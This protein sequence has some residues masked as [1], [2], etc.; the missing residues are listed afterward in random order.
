[1]ILTLLMEE[2]GMGPEGTLILHRSGPH[3]GSP[4]FSLE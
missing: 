3:H 4:E 1:M 2:H